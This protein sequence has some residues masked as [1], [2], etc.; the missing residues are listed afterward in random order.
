MILIIKIKKWNR[1]LPPHVQVVL[2]QIEV[3]EWK[4]IKLKI[5]RSSD[6]GCCLL[7]WWKKKQSICL[8][9]DS[10]CLHTLCLWTVDK[11]WN[12]ETYAIEEKK[13]R[14][15]SRIDKQWKTLLK[16]LIIIKA[17]NENCKQKTNELSAIQ[18]EPRKNCQNVTY[19]VIFY[20]C[21]YAVEAHWEPAQHTAYSPKNNNCI[22]P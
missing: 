21:K 20:M 6:C 1:T 19:F 13:E 7:R 17:N 3:S 14:N 10:I 5:I 4:K 15:N 9:F 8:L 12:M 2:S 16:I 18:A 11:A 22:V